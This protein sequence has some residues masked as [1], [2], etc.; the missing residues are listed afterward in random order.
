MRNLGIAENAVDEVRRDRCLGCF[1]PRRHC[2][3]AAIP[4]ID[5]QT[6]I[7]ILQHRRERFHPFNTARMV[8]RALRNSSLLV[9]HARG[10]AA[11]LVLRPR[12]GLLYPGAGAELLTNVPVDQRPR[13]LVVIDGTWHHAKTLVRDLPAL[14][15]LPRYSIA[16]HEP[17]RYRIRQEPSAILLS[18]VEATVAA[19]GVLEPETRG[20]DQLLNAF[21]SMVECQ[22]AHPKNKNGWRRNAARIRGGRNIPSAL[23]GSLDHIVVAYGESV[24][25]N[26]DR[27]AAASV[28][29]Y[30]AA[31][32]LGTGERFASAIQPPVPLQ[33]SILRHLELTEEHFADAPS[34]NE[35]Q[36][37]WE[38]FQRPNDIMAVYNHSTARLLSKITNRSAACLVLKSVDFNPHRRYSTLD[39]VAAGEGLA[40][41]PVCSPGRAV[42]RLASVVALIKHL[43]RLKN[44][45]AS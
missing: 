13:Q 7:L 35:V 30:W 26:H 32:R 8:H 10:L 15:D 43:R 31:Q 24:A 4:R 6:E 11:R 27:N 17:S 44:C 41:A 14:H 28:P 33:A 37:A 39:E 36:A 38:V 3:C 21:C 29:V 1:R 9:D 20:L 25:D 5:N 34:L 12:V 45:E 18:T 23:L 16:P 40:I 2:Y 42:K 19:L 22:L